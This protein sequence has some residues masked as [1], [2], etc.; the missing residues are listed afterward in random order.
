MVR[1]T[2]HVMCRTVEVLV[3]FAAV[4]WALIIEA[5]SQG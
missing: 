1:L 4:Q 5:W 3:A 2:A